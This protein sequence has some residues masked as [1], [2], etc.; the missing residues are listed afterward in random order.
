V[1]LVNEEGKILHKDSVPTLRE[2]PYQEII[3]DMA[4][5]TLKVIKDADVSI[6]QVKSIGVGSPGTRTARMEFLS[7]T[8]T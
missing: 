2:R 3:K 1:G 5:L 8:I 7:I 6:D 4:M